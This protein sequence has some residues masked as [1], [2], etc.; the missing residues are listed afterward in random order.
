LLVEE[1][2]SLQAAPL[3]SL[4]EQLSRASLHD[5][6]QLASPSGPGHGLPA[7]VQ[8]PLKHWSA[9]VQKRPSPL[10]AVPFALAGCVQAPPLHTSL[11]QSFPSSA[12]ASVLLV[13]WQAPL[14]QSSVVQILP[15]SHSALVP[16]C[17]D[18]TQSPAE[19]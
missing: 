11:V 4:A 3:G 9:P 14:T 7:L 13:C 5:S 12:Q 16:H 17:G 8:A 1:L 6:A 15:S 19:H 18:P 2:P 10:Q